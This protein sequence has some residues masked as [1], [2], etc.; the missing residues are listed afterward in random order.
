ME[1]AIAQTSNIAFEQGIANFSFSLY[2]E[3][4]KNGNE[5]VSPYSVSAAL[6]LLMLGTDGTTKAQMMSSIFKNKIP[7]D[8]HL[9]YRIL[10]GKLVDGTNTGATL[11]VANRLFASKIFKILD[12]YTTNA[13]TYYGSSMELLDFVTQPDQSRTRIND[14]IAT[15][16]NNKIQD[17]IPPRIIDANSIIVLANAIYFKGTWKTQ[18]EP[19]NTAKKTFF[20]GQNEHR[21]VDM[22]HGRFN[23]TSGDNLELGCKVL[24]VPFVGEK[25]EMV[26]LLPNDVTGLSRLERQLKMSSFQNAITGLR[27]HDTLIQIPKFV[28][29]SEYDLIPILT[30]LG[31]TEIFDSSVADFTHMVSP[32]LNSQGV[33][34]SDTRHKTYVE[35]NEEGSEAAASTTIVVSRESAMPPPFAFVADHPFLFVIR[36]NETGTPLFIGRYTDP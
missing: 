1:E 30:R 19:R 20:V 32:Q 21:S 3:V 16:T 13:L 5:L 31:F 15:Q 2:G 10:N 33:Y 11:S 23:A 8:I 27:K 34:V 6:L 35:V 36:E 14:W 17:M 18:F 7:R 4:E 12:S 24:R 9:G 22:M 26:F 28:I 29:E 25:L